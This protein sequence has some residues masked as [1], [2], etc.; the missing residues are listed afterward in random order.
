MY[1]HVD[2]CPIHE[3]VLKDGMVV[4]DI[5]YNPIETRLLKMARCRGCR[6]IDGLGMFIHQGAEQFR[7]WTGL[8]APINDMAHAL[9]AALGKRN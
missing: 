8:D 1:P 2:R 4:M 6:T 5:I 3:H 7:L 9:K